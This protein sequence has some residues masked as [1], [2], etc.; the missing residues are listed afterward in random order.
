MSEE[1]KSVKVWEKLNEMEMA[2]TQPLELPKEPLPRP[3]GE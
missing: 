1:S 2:F 3:I